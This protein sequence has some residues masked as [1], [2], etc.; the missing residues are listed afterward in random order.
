MHRPWIALLSFAFA[1]TLCSCTVKQDISGS[2][3]QDKSTTLERTLTIDEEN[4]TWSVDYLNSPESNVGGKLERNDE[5]LVFHLDRIV[6]L[7][8]GHQP[9]KT[10]PAVAQINSEGG[11][12]EAGSLKFDITDERGYVLSGTW[13]RASSG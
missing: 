12:P 3:V 2:Y 4:E 11:T 7:G 1:L 5:F 6:Y 9:A 10:D 13:R 8:E